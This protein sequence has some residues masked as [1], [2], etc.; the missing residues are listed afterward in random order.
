MRGRG[1]SAYPDPREPLA[2]LLTP[3]ASA[4]QHRKIK[5]KTLILGQPNPETKGKKY[6]FGA[7]FKTHSKT[8]FVAS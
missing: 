2:R 4:P 6:I 5:T 8:R 3:R 1:G 7:R